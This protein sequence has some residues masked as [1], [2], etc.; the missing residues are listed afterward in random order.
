M[1]SIVNS[2]DY[3]AIPA[4]QIAQHLMD[5]TDVR[6]LIRYFIYTLVCFSVYFFKFLLLQKRARRSLH[7]CPYC[8]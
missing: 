4:I 7:P 2:L 1:K 5:W 6:K 3:Q 8:P